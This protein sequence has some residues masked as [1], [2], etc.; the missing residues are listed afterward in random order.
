M[1]LFKHLVCGSVT[2]MLMMVGIHILVLSMRK[3][4]NQLEQSGVVL[5]T[6]NP[7]SYRSPLGGQSELRQETP[8]R[9]ECQWCGPVGSS[10]LGDLLRMAAE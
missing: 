3:M 5:A 4:G 9:N 1:C 8:R 6:W 7:K 2:M 10:Q